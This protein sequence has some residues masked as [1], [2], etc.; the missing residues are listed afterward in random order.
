MPESFSHPHNIFQNVLIFQ[1]TMTVKRDVE[2]KKDS[3]ETPGGHS[4]YL[5][6]GW[7][8][9]VAFGSCGTHFMVPAMSRSFGLIYLV[10]LDLFQESAAKTGFVVALFNTIRMGLGE[11][12][13]V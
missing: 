1:D 7:G 12:S 2:K 9:V 10:M 8:W 5:E 13:A 11:Y 4:A 3:V 6:G